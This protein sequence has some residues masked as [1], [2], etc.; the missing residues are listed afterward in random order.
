MAKLIPQTYQQPNDDKGS[1]KK[2]R[3]SELRSGRLNGQYH[4]TGSIIVVK[5]TRDSVSGF[6]SFGNS[7][8]TVPKSTAPLPANATGLLIDYLG[9]T[10]W[11]SGVLQASFESTTGNITA[12]AGVVTLDSDGITLDDANVDAALIKW[13]SGTDLTASI[14][15]YSTGDN[16]KLTVDVNPDAIFD[17]GKFHLNVYDTT[18]DTALFRLIS[19][20][21]NGNYAAFGSDSTLRGVTIGGLTEPN[22]MLD[23][24]GSLVVTGIISP[25]QITG[26]QNNYNPTGLST[27][28][29]VRLSS[30]A[31]RNITGLMAQTSG[32]ILA[33]HNIGAQNIV[34]IDSSG[35]SDAAN[36][37]DLTGDQ[38]LAPGDGCLVQYDITL[39]RWRMLGR[40]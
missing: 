25:S 20:N 14:G 30:D 1:R 18:G 24:R 19:D 6:I 13:K 21:T 12:G 16:A 17:L 7:I 15:T 39:T 26:D 28:F 3:P 36:Q 32:R 5:D 11:R 34:L 27:A 22:A 35:S 40:S 37:F 8:D 38:T 2:T 23:L 31:S 9:I 29:T 4:L 33:I 10:G